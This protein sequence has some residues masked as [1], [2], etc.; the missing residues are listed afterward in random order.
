MKIFTL[1]EKFKEKLAL[2]NKAQNRLQ[3]LANYLI[4]HTDK[5]L[6]SMKAKIYLDEIIPKKL[7]EEPYASIHMYF[8]P[9]SYDEKNL[10]DYEEIARRIQKLLG[11]YYGQV[12]MNFYTN[13]SII[14]NNIPGASSEV[15]YHA[16]GK[17]IYL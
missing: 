9:L 5:N 3:E 1:A 11:I 6:K 13:I 17:G 14:P 4:K 12:Y 15:A 2:G 10:K 8:K 16:P 7:T